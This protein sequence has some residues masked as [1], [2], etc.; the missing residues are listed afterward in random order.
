MINNHHQWDELNWVKWLIIIIIN[1]GILSPDRFP[2]LSLRTKTHHG[3]NLPW[4][5]YAGRPSSWSWW[6]WWPWGSW[7]GQT[8]KAKSLKRC[9]ENLTFTLDFPVNLWRAAFTILAMFLTNLSSDIIARI[10]N[11]QQYRTIYWWNVFIKNILENSDFWLHF[12]TQP[13]CWQE[14]I[15]ANGK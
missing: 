7:P 8:G 1:G 9:S 12:Q 6:S 13:Y 14:V 2:P 11:L 10:P 5:E 3:G 4:W 15:P